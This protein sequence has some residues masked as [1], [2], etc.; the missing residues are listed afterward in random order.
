MIIADIIA[1]DATLFHFDG[2]RNYLSDALHAEKT[3]EETE[4]SALM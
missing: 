4:W 1:V 2:S 3:L